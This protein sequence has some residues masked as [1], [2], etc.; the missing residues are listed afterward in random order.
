MTAE[1]WHGSRPPDTPVTVTLSYATVKRVLTAVVRDAK[2]TN[3]RGDDPEGV[4]LLA[5]ASAVIGDAIDAPAHRRFG[6][7]ATLYHAVIVGNTAEY[8]DALRVEGHNRVVLSSATAEPIMID[9][10]AEARLHC[11]SGWSFYGTAYRRPDFQ[12]IVAA[13]KAR[14]FKR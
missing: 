10:I 9:S 11:Y 8:N 5:Q 2:R 12:E 6:F 13:V 7:P 3:T 1:P 4:I 14:T